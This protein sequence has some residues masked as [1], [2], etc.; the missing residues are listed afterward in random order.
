MAKKVAQL[1]KLREQF[2]PDK[3]RLTPNQSEW[4]E[5]YRKALNRVESWKNKFHAVFD[6]PNRPENIHKK[7]IERLKNINWKKL[8]DVEKKK[9]REEYEY[10]YEQKMPEIYK[11]E[12]PYSPPTEQDYF[13]NPDDEDE[14]QFPWADEEDEQDEDGYTETVDSRAEIEEWIERVIDTISLDREI[15]EVREKLISLVEDAA[16]AN[17][18]SEDFYNYLEEN[19]D[20]FNELAV[21]ALHGYKKKSDGSTVHEEDGGENALP[22]FVTLLNYGRPID[23]YQSAEFTETGHITFDTTDL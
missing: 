21:K 15:P 1:K 5:E 13:D 19:S 18:Y 4:L 20:R 16:R 14:E 23:Q 9:A 11:P 3:K 17:D 8:A 10:K 7:D 6:M 2:F 22:A 12:P